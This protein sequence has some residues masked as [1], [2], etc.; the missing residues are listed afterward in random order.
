MNA[1]DTLVDAY[2]TG[3]DRTKARAVRDLCQ[4][5]SL[6]EVSMILQVSDDVLEAML[7]ET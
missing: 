1:I 7:G 4:R 5:L 2:R 3:N 6:P